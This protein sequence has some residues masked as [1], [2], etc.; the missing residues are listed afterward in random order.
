[1]AK[2]SEKY[3]IVPQALRDKFREYKKK[4]RMED[5]K[6]GEASEETS[7]KQDREALRRLI[8]NDGAMGG[9]A[10]ATMSGPSSGDT[11]PQMYRKGGMVKK[12]KGHRGDGCCIKGHTKGRMY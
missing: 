10:D 12:S 6:E 7:S 2:P 1:M 9:P 5:M 3:S 11:G 4:E 8:E